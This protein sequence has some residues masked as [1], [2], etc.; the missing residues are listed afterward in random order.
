MRVILV[1]VAIHCD[2]C[3]ELEKRIE[4]KMGVKIGKVRYHVLLFVLKNLHLRN[5]LIVC[6]AQR[7]VLVLIVKN[8]NNLGSNLRV[9]TSPAMNVPDNI[10][11]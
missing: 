5:L 3:N 4:I 10:E 7:K 2:Y 8:L 1:L 11:Q 9:N 6:W